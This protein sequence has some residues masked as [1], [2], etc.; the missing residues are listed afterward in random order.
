MNALSV[1]GRGLDDL[2][3]VNLARYKPTGEHVAIRRIDLESCTNDM[4]TYLQVGITLPWL[5]SLVVF[6]S[7]SSYCFIGN[8]YI[9]PL[10]VL[11]LSFLSLP[12]TLQ[13]PIRVRIISSSRPVVLT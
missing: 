7:P 9:T 3:T 6:V 4:V 2:M 5:R 1:S 10:S 11:W 12:L 13:F 8:T